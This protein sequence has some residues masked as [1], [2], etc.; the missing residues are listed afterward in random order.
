VL[1]DWFDELTDACEEWEAGMMVHKKLGKES[2]Q[3]KFSTSK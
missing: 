2:K 3:E 1:S